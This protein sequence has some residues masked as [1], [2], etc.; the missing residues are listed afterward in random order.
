MTTGYQGVTVDRSP[1][2]Q[3]QFDGTIGSFAEEVQK[4]LRADWE[5]RHTTADS[6]ILQQTSESYDT[7]GV[8]A[9]LEHH[10][11][12]YRSI[13][14]GRPSI[15]DATF[16]L[17]AAGPALLTNESLFKQKIMLWDPEKMMLAGSS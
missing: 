16:G 6:R 8:D 3:D 13:R 7:G 4:T 9:H 14:D 10:R 17:R 2:P 11:N 1:Q 5:A 12:F 15:E